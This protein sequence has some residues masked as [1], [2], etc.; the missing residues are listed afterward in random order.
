MPAGRYTLNVQPTR[1]PMG[2]FAGAPA[3]FDVDVNAAGIPSLATAAY[4]PLPSTLALDITGLPPSSEAAVV[5]TPP[6]SAA[7]VTPY[8]STYTAPQLATGQNTPDAWRVRSADVLV[9][10]TRYAASPSALDTIIPFGDSARVGVRYTVATG[11]LAVV[12]GGLPQGTDGNVLLLGPD[13]STRVL[14]STVTL[15]GLAP[16]H[17]RL[18]ARSLVRQGVTY[19]A[20]AD[21]ISID[22]RASLEA[23]PATVTYVAQVGSVT[24]AVNGLPD[25][26][27]A[28]ITLRNGDGTITRALSGSGIADSLPV[29]RYTVSAAVTSSASGDRYQPAPVSQTVVVETAAQSEALI[30]YSLASGSLALTLNGLPEGV[31]A[32]IVLSGPGGYAHR[33]LA[34]G[35]ITG[36][37]PGRYGIAVGPVSAGGETWGVV[38]NALA[39]DI[40]A[41]V[42]PIALTLQYQSLRTVIDMQVSGLPSGTNASLSLVGPSGQ[43][44]AIITSQTIPSVSPGRWRLT[45]NPVS[46]A[47]GKFMPD[48]ASSEGVVQPGDTLHFGVRYAI[49]TGAIALVVSGLPSGVSG[50]VIGTGPGGFN[51]SAT[52]TATWTGLAT[53]SYTITAAAV[54]A[55]DATYTPTSATQVVTVNAS[56]VAQP[57]TITYTKTSGGGAIGGGLNYRIA[58]V[59]LT[60]AIQKP[61]GSL[62]LVAGRDAMLRVFVVASAA[63][64]ARPDV[65]VR[66]YDGSTLLQSTTVTAPEASVRTATADGTLGSTWNLPVSGALM[67]TSLRVQVELDPTQAIADADRSDN[68]WPADGPSEAMQVYS[69][70]PFNVRFVPIV[71]GSRTGSVSS[72]NV[73]QYLDLT[74]QLWPIKDVVADVR[75]PFTASVSALQSNNG[76]NSWGTVLSELN[77]LRATD[78]VAS[79]MHYYG[80]VNVSYNSG[81]AGIGY[82]PGRSAVGWDHMPS[83]GKVAAHEWGH[84]F[85]RPHAPCGVAGESGFPY[86]GGIIGNW[87]WNS[88]TNTLVSPAATDLMGYCSNVWVS[89]YSWWQVMQYRGT[90]SL[91]TSASS[92]TPV[93]AVDGLLVWGRVVDGKITLEPA[94]RVRAPRTPAARLVTHRLDLI[95]ASGNALLQVPFE[96]ER[97]DHASGRDERQFALVVP[98]SATLEERLD[99][100]RVV[101]GRLPLHATTRNS[102][103]LKDLPR[104]ERNPP[105]LLATDADPEASLVRSGRDLRISWH[106]GA[107]EMALVTDAT[108]GSILGF[109]RQS[110]NAVT[111]GGRSVNVVFSDGVRSETRR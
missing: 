25:N 20:A 95:D 87:G 58:G 46:T 14:K 80:V 67:R 32:D 27:G 76:D 5:V 98:W 31:A 18:I 91:V 36:L 73:E 40:N 16:G 108:T 101:D 57:V 7:S 109:V 11:A 83:G 42:T 54:V 38:G 99:G 81:I 93:A 15:T 4:R 52:G 111:T 3:S 1:G 103:R 55:A 9:A 2:A 6:N 62:P 24:L 28:A 33:V 66:L 72:S 85:A 90:S 75:A 39:V 74:R 78:G 64:T 26:A 110:G 53:G 105:A 77:V 49:N 41:S 12:V 30:N 56:P 21:T 70:P 79:S 86:S 17:Y 44:Y 69:V 35:T 84:N 88:L 51:R 89:D 22:V 96:A 71:T 61:D 94:F 63:N 107:Y 8:S 106:N 29:G 50:A 37:T 45:A 59:H 34:S 65:R 102:A 13:N 47:L 10:G 100:I 19:R 104:G 23:A 92:V 48:P 97:V 68:V 60:Q 82:L 43:H